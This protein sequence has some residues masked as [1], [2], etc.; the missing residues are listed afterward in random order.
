[1]ENNI[2]VN[3]NYIIY[4]LHRVRTKSNGMLSDKVAGSPYVMFC[5]TVPFVLMLTNLSDQTFDQRFFEFRLM[6]FSGGWWDLSQ[7]GRQTDRQTDR[8]TG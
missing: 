5:Q 3:A 4:K 1:M 2:K 8:Q 7:T 6:F